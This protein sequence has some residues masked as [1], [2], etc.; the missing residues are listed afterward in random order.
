MAPADPRLPA[1]SGRPDHRARPPGRPQQPAAGLGP[2]LGVRGPGS[3]PAA[4]LTLTMHAAADRNAGPALNRR[5]AGRE[6]ANS[7]GDAT[8]QDL[9]MTAEQLFA[10][11]GIEAVP[12]RDIG[13]AAGQKNHAVVQYHFGDRESLV[14]EVIAFRASLSE[15][16]R[17]EM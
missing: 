10:E 1:R 14:R 6:R 17:V 8:R 15:R 12:L 5:V 7:R 3:W 2:A 9:L 4:T 11:R 16:L 13:S